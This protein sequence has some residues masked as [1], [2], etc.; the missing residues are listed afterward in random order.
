V[1]GADDRLADVLRGLVEAGLGDLALQLG[2]LEGGAR[3]E[4]LALGDEALLAEGLGTTEV[5]GDAFEG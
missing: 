2:D 1:R 5:A 3:V 4:Q